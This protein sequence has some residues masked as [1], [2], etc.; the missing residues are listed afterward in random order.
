M[1]PSLPRLVRVIPR[2][3]L[4]TQHASVV[5]I[6]PEPVRSDVERPTLIQIL[7][8]RKVEAGDDY[9]TNIRIEPVLKKEIFKGIPNNIREE[10]RGMVKEQ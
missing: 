3:K 10:L 1:R 8:K 6:L 4:A 5:R 7:Q 2:S 9:P